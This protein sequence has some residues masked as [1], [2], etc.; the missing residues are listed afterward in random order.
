[1]GTETSNSSLSLSPSDRLGT[2]SFSPHLDTELS[3]FRVFHE[4]ST[5]QNPEDPGASVSQVLSLEVIPLLGTCD[6]ALCAVQCC[7]AH[8]Y[9]RIQQELGS[10]TSG[11]FG[12]LN[13]LQ[14][15][16]AGA[17]LWL[18][19]LVPQDLNVTLQVQ[20]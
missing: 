3:H 13:S 14:L 15:Y 18:F 8:Y 4:P 12:P 6:P 17:W 5:T 16:E 19:M 1:M 20:S 7:K 9:T 10:H 2:V 11:L